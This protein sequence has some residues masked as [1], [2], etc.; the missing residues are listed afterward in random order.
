MGASGWRFR[1]VLVANRGEIAVRVIAACRKLGLRAVAVYSEADADALHARLA[2]VAFCIGPAAP[3][4]SYLNAEALIEAAVRSGAEAVHPGYGFLSEDPAFAERCIAAG[5][6]WVGPPPAAMRLLGDKA[7]AKALAERCGVP[8]LPG[9]HGAAQDDETLRCAAERLGFPLLI[10]AA[11]GGGGRGMRLVRAADELVEALEAARREAVAAFGDGRLLLERYVERPRH[12]EVQV[13]GDD[14]GEV[15]YL[16][17]RDCSLQR[18]HQKVIEEAPA[19]GL[20]DGQRRVLGEAAV[21]LARAA[22]YRNAGTVEFLLDGEGRFY[23]LEVNTRLQVEHPVTEMVTG[24]DLV[25]LQLRVANGERLPFAQHEVVV[26]GH[27]IECRLYAEDPER[28][29]LPS[30]GRVARLA[31]PQTLPN[32]RVDAGVEEGSEVPPYYDPLL[33]KIIVHGATRHRALEQMAEALAGV[34]V[35][36]VRTNLELLRRAVGST[37]FE[38]ADLHTGLLTT[39]PIGQPPDEDLLIAAAAAEVLGRPRQ[40]DGAAGDPWRELGPWRIGWV[41][42]EVRYRVGNEIVRIGLRPS[43]EPDEPWHFELPAGARQRRVRASGAD[44][45]LVEDGERAQAIRVV[46]QGR[47]RLVRRGLLSVELELASGLRDRQEGAPLAGV[48]SDSVVRAPLPGRIVKIA[49]Q[50]GQEVG[51]NQTLLVLEAM[52]IEHLVGAPR[53]GRVRRVRCTVGDQ[54]ELGAVLIELEE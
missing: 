30:S 27:A 3:S 20:S 1:S 23:L 12:V 41:G 18:R 45:V 35:E 48:E 16:G 24:L 15:V 53:D 17:E 8:V 4:A 14:H 38:Q 6:I 13:L 37:A 54:V 5:L 22:G 9:Y 10:K 19:P 21:T 39:L 47:R 32:V 2:D 49:V 11:A 40:H 34:R 25:E 51:T 7:N 43:L 33:A 42:S 26:R 28:G 46:R 29:F 31:L 36:G 50:P 44:A 52:K